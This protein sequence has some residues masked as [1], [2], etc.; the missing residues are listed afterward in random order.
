MAN[1]LNNA[2]IKI[3]IFSLHYT[4]SKINLWTTHILPY[5][6]FNENISIY[7]QL[8]KNKFC[9]SFYNSTTQSILELKKDCLSNTPQVINL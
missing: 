7:Y 8:H 9:L 5:K 2:R 6:V 3:K 1:E 4:W